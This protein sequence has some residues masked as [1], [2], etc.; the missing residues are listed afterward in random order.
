MSGADDEAVRILRDSVPDLA[1][2]YRFGS[3]SAGTAGPESDVDLAVLAP[4]RL[5]A[6]ARAS[7]FRNTLRGLD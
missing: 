7:I 4:S 2:V 5:G 6:A 1:A 3:T